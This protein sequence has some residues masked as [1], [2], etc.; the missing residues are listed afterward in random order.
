M[1]T[2]AEVGTLV[3]HEPPVIDLLP[4]RDQVRARIQDV[5]DTYR[6]DCPDKAMPKFMAHA[7]LAEPPAQDSAA[8]RWEPIPEQMAAMRAAGETFL[9]HLPRQTT[10]F[11]PDIEALRSARTRIVV[12][13]GATSKGQLAHRSALALA[14]RL[15]TPAVEFPGNHGGFVTHPAQCAQ[16]L[17]QLL[18]HPT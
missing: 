1:V 17:D 13:V 15:A 18:T 10:S 16:V 9:A 4:D 6:T 12:A 11:R 8:P 14:D 3:A 7:G 5:Y 2:R